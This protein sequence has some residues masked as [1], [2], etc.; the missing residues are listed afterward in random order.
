MKP[1]ALGQGKLAPMPLHEFHTEVLG[2]NE[3]M[4]DG[5]FQ[6]SASTKPS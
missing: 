2:G 1:A 3:V 4:C 6:A 5:D